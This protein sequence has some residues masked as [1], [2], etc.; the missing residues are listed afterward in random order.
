M[1]DDSK[2]APESQD[3]GKT[4][5]IIGLPSGLTQK[6]VLFGGIY[7]EMLIG[8][9]Q[10]VFFLPYSLTLQPEIKR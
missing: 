8:L 6:F 2:K 1:L 7:Q 5:I 9:S 3:L 4:I 10:N